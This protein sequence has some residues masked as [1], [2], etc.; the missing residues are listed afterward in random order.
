MD[1]VG[2]S[3]Y[4]GTRLRLE[5]ARD[6]EALNGMESL[7]VDDGRT[8]G[9][10]AQRTLL[11]R[12]LR[13]VPDGLDAA[14]V[15][16]AGGERVDP[17]LNPVRVQWAVPAAG[18]AAAQAADP[19]GVT[20]ADV[21]AFGS[22]SGP[23]RVLVVR[24]SSSG[25]F[26]TYRFTVTA[27]D[28]Y[29]LDPRLAEMP[30]TFKADCPT[31]F[32]PRPPRVTPAAPVSVPPADY[33]QRDYTGLRRVL[34]DRLS[35]L[36]PGWSE[37][38]AA[39]LGVTLVELFAYLGDQLAYA[40]D[41]VA[42]EA[43]LG[44]ARHRV[45]VRRHARLLDYPMHD[46]AAARTWLAVRVEDAAEGTVLE[47]DTEVVTGDRGGT[48]T[49]FHTL[50]PG[51]ALAARNSIDIYAWGEERGSLPAGATSATLVGT[52]AALALHTGDVLVLEEVR[53]ADGAAAGADPAH[54][55][56]VRL[57]AEPVA[58]HD[59]V[60]G[61][62]LL[63][64]SW[65]QGD[66]LPFPLRLWR[67]PG[68]AG[69]TVGAAVARGNVVLAEHGAL[70]GPELLLPAEV[71]A[72]GRYRPRLAGTGLAHA[73]PYDHRRAVGR[74]AADALALRPA[75]AAPALTALHDGADAWTAVPDLLSSGRFAA[76]YVVETED[77]GRAYLRFGDGVHGRA[78]VPETTFRAV[79]R[80][81]GGRAGNV[82]RDALT[83]LSM[84]V[85]GV[86]VRNPMPARGGADPE[87]VEQVRQWAPQ[88]FRVQQRAVT[89]A[90]YAEAAERQPQVR[91][92]VAAR[93]WTG[94]WY[95]ETVT[96]DRDGGLPADRRFR[97]R[98]TG[99]LERYRMAGEDVRVTA[100][101]PVSLDIVL[102]VHVAPGHLRGEVKQALRDVFTAGT[103]AD[104]SPG[105]FHPGRFAFAQPVHL[106][107]LVA[108]AMGVPGVLWV[109]T[110][111]TPPQPG[112][113]Q[114]WG[115]PAAREREEGRIPM[116]RYE[117]ARCQSDPSLPEHGRIDF[118]MEGGR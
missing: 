26:S 18:L 41:A 112:R 74:P 103:R 63:R 88:A 25:D 115:R 9:T 62:E 48:G 34:L 100:A 117:V 114:R 53:G 20:A 66:A 78:P 3:P 14:A 27:P 71:P 37:R 87:P 70:T 104:G 69:T 17:A 56:A 83:R 40:Q 94:S 16:V 39:D 51:T 28:R 99:S 43:Y 49:V 45:S 77:D 15:A 75:D 110:D 96:V 31:D 8:P 108:A 109:G 35:L 81:G 46:G 4:G 1:T 7:E 118:V 58:D 5:A 111:T 22:L 86:T 116:G 67:F 73:V 84:P 80:I 91:Q 64:V 54:R 59:P 79:Y 101:V 55:W 89:D 47:S 21:A 2:E 33:L 57:D 42:T 107:P 6:P 23:E 76:E 13:R 93:R 61:T 65:G 19:A 52:S 29:G 97:D 95:T 24:T 82:G 60:T 90:D 106:S 102:T 105:Y 50:H 68:E 44:T 12:F 85:D 92:A 11:V 36:L 30:F 72:V 32:D 113:F 98:V 10:P 38:S